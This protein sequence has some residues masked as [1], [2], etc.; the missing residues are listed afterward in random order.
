MKESPWV[1][2]FYKHESHKPNESDATGF[3]FPKE[4]IDW[5]IDRLMVKKE[6]KDK[7][8]IT[9]EVKLTIEDAA[10]TMEDAISKHTD[11]LTKRLDYLQ[12]ALKQTQ[13]LNHEEKRTGIVKSNVHL[14]DNP[15]DRETI[16]QE[17]TAPCPRPKV[18]F[19]ENSNDQIDCKI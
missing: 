18:H 8:S 17:T 9:E 1:V 6:M 12:E 14:F 13:S 3:R 2:Y 15:S 4:L 5:T 16:G 10:S 19:Q 7:V 11:T